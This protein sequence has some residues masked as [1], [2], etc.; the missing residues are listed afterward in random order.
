MVSI[1][2]QAPV[3]HVVVSCSI[4]LFQTAKIAWRE[5]KMLLPI[6]TDQGENRRLSCVCCRLTGDSVL[7]RQP[8]DQQGRQDSGGHGDD[9]GMRPRRGT[10]ALLNQCMSHRTAE[11]TD[12]AS[13]H[14]P[15]SRLHA[16][17]LL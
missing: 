1:N 13:H 9:Q 2:A 16:R 11:Q 8:P 4:G 12:D 17:L 14:P 3:A 10:I 5:E 15:R 7:T 6:V